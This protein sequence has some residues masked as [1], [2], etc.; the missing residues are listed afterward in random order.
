MQIITALGTALYAWHQHGEKLVNIRLLHLYFGPTSQDDEIEAFLKR[1]NHHFERLEDPTN[2]AAQ[3]LSSK[4]SVSS[5][6]VAMESVTRALGN[7][8]NLM[9]ARNMASKEILNTKVKFRESFRPFCPVILYENKT[10][11]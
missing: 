8:S 10:G 11:I 7:R 1:R 9:S 6:Q 2:T 3:L 4:Y 5:F